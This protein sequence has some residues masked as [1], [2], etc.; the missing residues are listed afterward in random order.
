MSLKK[1]VLDSSSFFNNDAMGSLLEKL[2]T[3]EC[4]ISKLSNNIEKTSKRVTEIENAIMTSGTKYKSIG[5]VVMSQNRLLQQL[6]TSAASK[7]NLNFIQKTINEFRQTIEKT[8]K[9]IFDKQHKMQDAIL[10]TMTNDINAVNNRVDT[11]KDDFEFRLDQAENTIRS[12]GKSIKQTSPTIKQLQISIDELHQSASVHKEQDKKLGEIVLEL[13][14]KVSNRRDVIVINERIHSLTQAMESFVERE[15]L[16]PMEDQVDRINKSMK[17]VQQST[18]SQAQL[19]KVMRNE[20]CSKT[21]AETTFLTRK[22]FDEK[23][24]DIFKEISKK[25]LLDTVSELSQTVDNLTEDYL[26]TRNK[27]QISSDFVQWFTTKSD[28]HENMTQNVEIHQKYNPKT[29][30]NSAKKRMSRPKYTSDCS[31]SF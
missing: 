13:K 23:V 28:A 19:L 9:D 16:F 18:F 15:A 25:A 31:L 1:N 17:S 8:N 6:A 5:E 7:D 22:H 11:I 2:E 10:L 30:R 4:S 29:K 24:R 27:A 26:L 3:L 14:D 20:M 12:H 21:Q